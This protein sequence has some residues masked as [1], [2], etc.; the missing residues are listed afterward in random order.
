MPER[1][2]GHEALPQTLQDMFKGHTLTPD[3]QQEVTKLISDYQH[4]LWGPTTNWATLAGKQY[5]CTFD[6]ASSYSQL[7]MAL[8]DAHKSAFITHMGL[9]EW[10]VLSQE[11]LNSPAKFARCMDKVLKGLV[12]STVWCT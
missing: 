4:M 10:Q 3:Q 5:F 1:I 11:F 7:P 9:F 2:P 6:L 8:E 12:A